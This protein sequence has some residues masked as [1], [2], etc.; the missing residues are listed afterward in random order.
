MTVYDNLLDGIGAVPPE[1]LIR[2]LEFA[3]KELKQAHENLTSVQALCTAQL[4]ELR[5][6]RQKDSWN[7]PCGWWNPGSRTDCKGCSTV[8]E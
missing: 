7:C 4:E 6:Y 2:R 5:A 1:F 8:R 3:V